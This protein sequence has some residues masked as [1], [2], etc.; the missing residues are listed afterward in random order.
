[1]GTN[2]SVYWFCLLIFLIIG[3]SPIAQQQPIADS[4]KK[5]SLHREA[6]SAIVLTAAKNPGFFDKDTT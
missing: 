2:K 3:N 1:M 4:L 5:D 6:E